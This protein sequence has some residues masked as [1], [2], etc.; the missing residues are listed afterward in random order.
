MYNDRA[1]ILPECLRSI[2]YMI[3]L[4][5]IVIK[6]ALNENYGSTLVTGAACKVAERTDKVGEL[7]GSSTLRSHV[8]NEVASLVLDALGDSSL[9]SLTLE[10]LVI[11]ISEI[12]K[13][14]LVG[15]S[16]ESVGKCGRNYRVCK[17]PDLTLGILEGTVT[18]NHYLNVSAGSIEYSLLDI[19]NEIGAFVGEEL[20]LV[21]GGLVRTEESVLGVG[22]GIKSRKERNVFILPFCPKRRQ[23]I[24]RGVPPGLPA[25][26][27]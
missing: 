20:Y 1:K 19:V 24:C 14:K 6:V 11:V 18:V 2:C 16:H 13:L 27:F 5:G 10:I 9:K 12:L 7:A 15:S 23:W 17:L 3:L 21:L 26:H 25:G 4:I 22:N 8:S